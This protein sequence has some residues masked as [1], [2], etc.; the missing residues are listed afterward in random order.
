MS[1]NQEAS[2]R[3]ALFY[4]RYRKSGKGVPGNKILST[5]EESHMDSV[6]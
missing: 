5:S 4:L 2:K 3:E 1:G 6:S